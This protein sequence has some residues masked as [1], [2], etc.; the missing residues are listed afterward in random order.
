MKKGTKGITLIALVITIIVILILAGVTLMSLTGDNGLLSKS[1]D[2][3]NKHLEEEIKEQIELAL[4][5][6][7]STRT[8]NID[9]TFK[10]AIEKQHINYSEFS[11][12]DEE[13][14]KIIVTLKNNKEKLYKVDL[15]GLIE[16]TD[17]KW[18]KLDD[19]T[20]TDGNIELKVGD[21]ILYDQT[22]DKNGNDVEIQ[23]YTSYSESN[24]SPKKNNGRTSGYTEDQ[25]FNENEYSGGW[26]L[27]DVEYGSLKLISENSVG[28]Y[29]LRGKNGYIYGVE[30]LNKIGSIYGQGKWAEKGRCVNTNDINKITGYDPNKTGNE[31]PYGKGGLGEYGKKVTYYWKGDSYPYY[32]SENDTK[33]SLEVSHGSFYYYD[34]NSWKNS[35]KSQNAT[36][37]EIGREA[38]T[39]LKNS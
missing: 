15:E 24:M 13:G 18:K 20:I 33:G 1:Q 28:N 19:G 25:T 8:K 7:Q 16:C 27:L 30:E 31:N 39:T 9:Y 11:G 5:D 21:Y 34:G 2:A 14:Y 38:I 23:S 3:T 37:T 26:R 6:Y 36:D 10:Q 12:N 22:K 35:I 17:I 4:I 29:T 32:Q